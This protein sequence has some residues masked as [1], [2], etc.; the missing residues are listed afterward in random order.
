MFRFF[1][2]SSFTLQEVLGDVQ[3][4]DVQFFDGE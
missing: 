4:I 3:S 1:N 2:S